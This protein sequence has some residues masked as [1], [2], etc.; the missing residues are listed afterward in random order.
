MN[1]KNTI[2]EGTVKLHF[3]PVKLGKM[4]TLKHE[5]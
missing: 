1:S 4:T 5:G 2:L 3:L